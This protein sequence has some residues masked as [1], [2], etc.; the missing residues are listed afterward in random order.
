MLTFVAELLIEF[1]IPLAG[2]LLIDL[3]SHLG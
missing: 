2:E 3:L 1:L